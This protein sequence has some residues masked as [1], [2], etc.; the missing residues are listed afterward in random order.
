MAI[1]HEV[2]DFDATIKQLDKVLA[3]DGDSVKKFSHIPTLDEMGDMDY[4]IANC[5]I[6]FARVRIKASIESEPRGKVVSFRQRECFYRI[7][8]KLFQEHPKCVDFIFHDD[9][10]ACIV[11]TPFKTDI[12]QLFEKM[13]KLNSMLSILDQKSQHAGLEPM[14]WG[15][16][17]HYGETFVTVQ[18][19]NAGNPNFTWSGYTYNYAHFLCEKAIENSQRPIISS[20]VF[21]KNLKDE[22]KEMMHKEDGDLYSANVINRPIADWQTKN[23]DNK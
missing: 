3:S 21:Y 18:R 15:I 11:D 6:V 4:Y 12:H 10:I 19:Y 22:Y 1:I 14:E 7:L 20:E 23:I 13:A 9:E 8:T 16:G 17:A 5:S 2:F